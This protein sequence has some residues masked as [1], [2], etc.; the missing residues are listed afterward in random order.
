MQASVCEN[1]SLRTSEAS[2]CTKTFSF[3]LESDNILEK[4]SGIILGNDTKFLN[5]IRCKRAGKHLTINMNAIYSTKKHK[6]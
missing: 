2:P 1:A 3:L 5:Q 6:I 4:T